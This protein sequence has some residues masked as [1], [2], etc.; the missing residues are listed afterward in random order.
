MGGLSRYKATQGLEYNYSLTDSHMSD[1]AK[2]QTHSKRREQL[3]VDFE[4]KHNVNMD[5]VNNSITSGKGTDPGTI[6]AHANSALKAYKILYPMEKTRFHVRWLQ[7]MSDQK[8]IDYF[9]KWFIGGHDR[10]K[11]VFILGSARFGNLGKKTVTS[12]FRKFVKRLKEV[13]HVLMLDEFMTTAACSACL[14]TGVKCSA[15]DCN[16]VDPEDDYFQDKLS[17]FDP[18]AGLIK[19]PDGSFT[20]NVNLLDQYLKALGVSSEEDGE[21]LSNE[22][23]EDEIENM[24]E[25]DSNSGGGVESEDVDDYLDKGDFSDIISSVATEGGTGDVDPISRLE[26]DTGRMEST[27][28]VDGDGGEGGQIEEKKRAELLKVRANYANWE[29]TGNVYAENQ[30]RVSVDSA[31]GKKVIGTILKKEKTFRMQKRPDNS[32]LNDREEDVVNEA[33]RKRGVPVG[34]ALRGVK[35][36]FHC[37]VLWH[38]DINAARN[39][40]IIFLYMKFNSNT[41]PFLYKRGKRRTEVVVV[42]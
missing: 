8:A 31:A 19:R 16:P 4:E 13:I 15:I 10:S 18:T 27:V 26:S 40:L 34:H 30:I 6:L 17:K 7:Y 36:C 38:R 11:I 9:I 42:S 20:F 24:V 21:D 39:I 2:R 12:L 29:R 22:L 41:R 1:I 32:L 3:R 14:L 35:Q 28:L 23:D 5:E 25:E 37:G 33:Y